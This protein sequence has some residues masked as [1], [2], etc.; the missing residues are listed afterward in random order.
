MDNFIIS[1]SKE[2]SQELCGNKA[3]NLFIL[4][5]LFKIPPF[6]VISTNA[7]KVKDSLE[8]DFW[9]FLEQERGYLFKNEKLIVRSS[10]TMEDSEMKS[11]AGQYNSTLNVDSKEKL[12]EAIKKTW[13]SAYV[14]NPYTKNYCTKDDVNVLMGVIIQKQI[15][16]SISGI[17]AT[18]N[19]LGDKSILIECTKGLG[20]N[21]ASGLLNPT[22][23]K[24]INDIIHCTGEDILN[25]KDL[26][27]LFKIG[28]K[29]EKYFNSP[30][31]IEWCICDNTIYIVQCRPIRIIDEDIFSNANFRETIP[32]PISQMGWSIWNEILFTKVLVKSF[33]FIKDKKY[34]ENNRIV[35]KYYGRL[36]FNLNNLCKYLY[37]F[38]PFINEYEILSKID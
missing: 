11:F 37:F 29:C 4:E 32:N 6:I 26:Y 20:D 14:E 18:R 12:V 25:R 35:K 24:I 31:D 19:P 23:Y 34:F 36:Y 10:S 13:E 8:Q 7:F 38:R 28:R 33:K 21:L 17:L 5:K 15:N 22:S 2:S 9:E 30:Q 27:K 1:N 3:H 16:P